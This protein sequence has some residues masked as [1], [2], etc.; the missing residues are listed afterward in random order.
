MSEVTGPKEWKIKTTTQDPIR[1][2]DPWEKQE[3]EA[4]A[5]EEPDKQ[6]PSK[7]PPGRCPEIVRIL[8]F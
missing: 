7:D 2:K 5:G 4:D 1:V 6:N 8:R 3:E